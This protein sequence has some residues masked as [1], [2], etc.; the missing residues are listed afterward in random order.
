MLRATLAAELVLV[1]IGAG[2]FLRVS[3]AGLILNFVAIP[4]MAAI[5]GAGILIVLLS[6]WADRAAAAVARVAE[7]ACAVLLG[8]AQL[9]DAAPWLVWRVPPP[10]PVVS[11][12]FYAAAVAAVGA[13]R[14]QIEGV[15][16]RECRRAAAHD[17]DGAG[18]RV[19]RTW[20]LMDARHDR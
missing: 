2:V 18:T 9:V 8:S 7:W 1:P 15:R 13:R 17:R 14:P 11:A 19:G 10:H 12:A 16:R 20:P 5:Q 6:G 4:A 3:A